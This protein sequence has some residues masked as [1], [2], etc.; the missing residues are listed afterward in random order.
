VGSREQ[1]EGC[2]TYIRGHQEVR[3]VL[4]SGGD[5]LTMTDERLDWLLGQL[6]QIPHVEIVRIG[7]KVPAVLPSASRG[8]WS[9]CSGASSAL[10]ELHFMHP[11]ELT[12][13]TTQALNRLADAGIPLGSQTVLLKGINDQVDTLKRLFQGLLRSRVRPY[14]LY[15]CDP[16]HGSEHFRTPV[17]TGLEMI[18]ACAAYQRVCCPVLCH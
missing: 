7:T 12:A 3:D 2:L 1:W 13:E 4:I 10:A 15:Q 17:T 8:S 11:D 14:Y 6:R 5:P 16:I 9:A 18:A